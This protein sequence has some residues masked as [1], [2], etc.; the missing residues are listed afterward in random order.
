[1]TRRFA[2]PLA[3]AAL[4]LAAIA[5]AGCGEDEKEKFIDD[6]KPLNDRLLEIGRDLGT[7]LQNAEGKSNKALSEQ[8]AGYALR[9]ESV[10]KDIRALDT[11]TVLKDESNTLASR[12]DATVKNLKE[13]S[14]AAG[15]ND[16]QAAAAATV[17]LA[18]NSQALNRAQNR[19][20]KATGAKVGSN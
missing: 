15:N 6:Y 7:G 17:E 14:G 13:I 2:L 1:M 10:N 9:L 11:P 3:L 16:P 19:L 8:F 5:I 12:I 4:A 20:A 18:T